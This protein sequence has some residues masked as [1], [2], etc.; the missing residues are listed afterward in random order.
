MLFRFATWRSLVATSAILSA[1]GD[2]PIAPPQQDADL[3]LLHATPNLG[4]VDVVVGGSIVIHGV[5][6]GNSSAVVQV[7]AGTQHVV[8]RSGSLVL[9]ELDYNLKTSQTNNLVVADSAVSFSSVVTPD[10]GAVSSARANV[11]MV[12]VVGSNPSDPVLLDV[13]VKAPN[14]NP[15][16]VIKFGLDTRVASYGTLM[17]FDPGH[18]EF[19]YVPQ[20]TT[21]VLT[22]VTFDVALG[23]TKAV[24][25]ERASDGTYSATVVVEQ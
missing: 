6:F 5:T 19:K 10:T 4:A 14:A 8:V 20:G 24:V 13:L 21:N 9:G 11:R 18:F 25:L 7:A 17:Y 12:N 22:Q 15:D 2:S 3:R 16:S 23:E 1:C